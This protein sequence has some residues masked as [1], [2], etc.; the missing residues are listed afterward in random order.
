M[1][2]PSILNAFERMWQHV[3][4]ALNNKSDKNHTH[5]AEQIGAGRVNPNL[6]D[7]WYF[8]NPVDQRGGWVL[9]PGVEVFW[10]TGLTSSTGVFTF[11]YE[12]CVMQGNVVTY[13]SGAAGNVY[14]PASAAVRGYTG[15]GYTIDR[16][17]TDRACNVL[18][19]SDGLYIRGTETEF[20][21]Y[22]VIENNL[23]GETVT[24]S[25]LTDSGIFVVTKVATTD[26]YDKVT[27]IQDVGWVGF[28]VNSDGTSLAFI[29]VYT[30]K[31]LKV[32]AAKLEL[33]TG[34]TLAHQDENGNW[35][36]NE[37]PNYDEQLLR[38]CM[39]TADTS[40]EYAN[41]KKTASV[42]NTFENKGWLY[43][44]STVL[45][46]ATYPTKVG[47][48]FFEVADTG[49][50]VNAPDAPF[51]RAETQY[52]VLVDNAD[53]RR[54]TVLAYQ[55]GSNRFM[56]RDIFDGNWLIEWVEYATTDYVLPRDGSAVMTGGLMQI[57]D[58][59]QGTVAVEGN[60]NSYMY[61][62]VFNRSDWDHRRTLMLSSIQNSPSLSTAL[63][64]GSL[65][66]GTW[67]EY[68][69]IHTGNTDQ[70]YTYGTDD[71][72]VGSSSPYA[73]GHI[74]FVIE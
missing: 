30:E 11:K 67:K 7:N 73:N 12:A 16:W 42:L 6:L 34:Q 35:V 39:S 28:R 44:C 27:L 32:K 56:K 38:C 19:E 4:V 1:S 33:G 18:L 23:L 50:L 26:L 74:H 21:F 69:I 47:Y 72:Q 60:S 57:N 10:D 41:N 3:T 8:G 29:T 40:D 55:Y 63:V 52:L 2:N 51:G 13:V 58:N 25:I 31:H 70:I 20:G 46:A 65:D 22:Q 49:A 59:A 15:A 68:P 45:E 43:N 71:I 17:V 37:I 62:N 48:S 64:L 53:S 54:R 66:D 36:L 14:A 5:T 61:I 9:P 24:F